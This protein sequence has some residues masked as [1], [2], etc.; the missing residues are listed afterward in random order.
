MPHLVEVRRVLPPAFRPNAS[1]EHEEV[2]IAESRVDRLPE[3]GPVR[4][5]AYV[6]LVRLDFSLA[7]NGRPC[8]RKGA[9]I[10]V[11]Q[12]KFHAV[13]GAQLGHRQ[14]NATGGARDQG[15]GMGGKDGVRH[16][17]VDRAML[18]TRLFGSKS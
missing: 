9:A 18:C 11:H 14:T 12:R 1:V 6:G 13:A 16:G 3:T 2:D 5:L 7:A 10:D 8:L 17:E 4:F 15:C